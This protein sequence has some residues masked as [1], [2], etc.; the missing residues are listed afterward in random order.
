MSTSLSSSV[1]SLAS[2]LS[3][4]N[5]SISTLASGTSD[6][7]RLSRVLSQTRHFELLHERTL[8]SAQSSLMSE[9]VPAIDRLLATASTEIEKVERREEG[10][11]ARSELLEGRLEREEV[12]RSLGGRSRKG[13]V[14]GSLGGKGGSTAGVATGEKAAELKRLRREK[15][16]LRYAVERLELQGRQ[17]ERELRKSMAV[18]R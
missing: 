3:L 17:R 2:S 10:F 11:R 15:E 18:V 7:P 5:S 14:G 12:R 8:L 9:I 16:R 4:L 6:L 1:S 13:S